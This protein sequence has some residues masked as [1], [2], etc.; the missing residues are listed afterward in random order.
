MGNRPRPSSL[1]L[2]LVLDPESLRSEDR[3]ERG[4]AGGGKE[5]SERDEH[6]NEDDTEN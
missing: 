3:A 2:V 6:E 4:G 1:V 5:R